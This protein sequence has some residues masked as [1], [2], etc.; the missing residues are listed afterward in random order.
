MRHADV[1][2]RLLGAG[3]ALAA[4]AA[5]RMTGRVASASGMLIEVGGL[6]AGLAVGDRIQIRANPDDPAGAAAEV[7]GF[8][9]GMARALAFGALDGLGPRSAASVR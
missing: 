7:V 4:A 8:R 9:A 1:V 5:P 2:E 6:S 3:P